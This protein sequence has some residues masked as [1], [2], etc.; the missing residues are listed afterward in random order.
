MPLERQQLFHRHVP[1]R[2]EDLRASFSSGSLATW[3]PRLLAQIMRVP[4]TEVAP[5]LDNT[6]GGYVTSCDNPGWRP[7]MSQLRH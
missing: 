5:L 3:G 2:L 4:R 6:Y 7:Q 1:G